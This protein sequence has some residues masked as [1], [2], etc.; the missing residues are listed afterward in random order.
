M[1][2]KSNNRLIENFDVQYLHHRCWLSW[3]NQTF[4]LSYIVVMK[5]SWKKIVQGKFIRQSFRAT[6][7]TALSGSISR[8][9]TDKKKREY[10]RRFQC[11]T[12]YYFHEAPVVRNDSRRSNK[13]D[14]DFKVI[15]LTKLRENA[16]DIQANPALCTQRKEWK[17]IYHRRTRSDKRLTADNIL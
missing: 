4:S 8:I 1:N 11:V 16:H 12:D 13:S 5:H 15:M 6:S 10:Q 3:R 17:V 9:Q 7:L 2:V 14:V